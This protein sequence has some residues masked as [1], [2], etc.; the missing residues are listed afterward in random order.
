MKNLFAMI[1][2]ARGTTPSITVKI[3][4][5]K[6]NNKVIRVGGIDA[7]SLA[8]LPLP[9]IKV[10]QEAEKLGLQG[11]CFPKDNA[12]GNRSLLSLYTDSSSVESADDA[13]QDWDNLS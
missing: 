11:N 13:Y 3:S 7:Q 4:R 10:T 1:F 5:S 6:A 2:K 8:S 9:W 12:S